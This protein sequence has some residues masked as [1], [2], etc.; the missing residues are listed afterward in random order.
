[1]QT[2]SRLCP[3]ARHQVATPCS[4]SLP[5]APLHHTTPPHHARLHF[6]SCSNARGWGQ[7][8]LPWHSSA[9]GNVPPHSTST[10]LRTFLAPHRSPHRTATAQIYGKA[11]PYTPNGV[12]GFPLPL[13][14]ISYA[15]CLSLPTFQFKQRK[16]YINYGIR[17]CI[18]CL[19]LQFL[20]FICM[21]QSTNV[22]IYRM[23]SKSNQGNY[24]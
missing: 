8:L 22:Y 3:G 9:R 18:V 4:S 1:M 21:F 20:H 19:G 23:L 15:P 6:W 14:L 13:L 17:A 7:T 16:V 10:V 12:R 24:T 5:P 2:Q 11:M